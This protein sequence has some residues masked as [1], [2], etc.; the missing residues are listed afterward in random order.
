M[1]YV[2]FG[3][4]GFGICGVVDSALRMPFA[5]YPFFDEFAEFSFTELWQARLLLM[6]NMLAQTMVGIIGGASLGAALGHLEKRKLVRER[7]AR[8]R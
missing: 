7:S 8:V 6:Q 2:I 4:V 1:R 3:A 5:L